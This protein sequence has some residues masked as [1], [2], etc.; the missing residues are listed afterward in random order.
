VSCRS[1]STWLPA[2]FAIV[3]LPPP[4]IA[5]EAPSVSFGASV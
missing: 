5:A 2:A 1:A 4:S 3:H